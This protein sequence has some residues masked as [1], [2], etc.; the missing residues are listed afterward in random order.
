MAWVFG[1]TDMKFFFFI[2][3]FTMGIHACTL[4]EVQQANEQT[5]LEAAAPPAV[6][7]VFGATGDLTARKLVP[8]I[9]HLFVP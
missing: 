4:G 5:R 8:A 2:L 6:F 7:V 9:Y 1:L 3:S